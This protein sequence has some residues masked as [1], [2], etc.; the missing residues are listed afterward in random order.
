MAGFAPGAPDRVPRT[1]PD[2]GSHGSGP[3]ECIYERYTN[4]GGPGITSSGYTN[5][6]VVARN[7]RQSLRIRITNRVSTVAQA[8]CPS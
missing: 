7:S 3:G 4:P 8:Q 2:P 1:I 6:G 5:P